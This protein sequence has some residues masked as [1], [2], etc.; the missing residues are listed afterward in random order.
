[1][2]ETTGIKNPNWRGGRVIAS[3]GY[4]LIRVGKNHHLADVR[5][6]A[7]EHRLVAEKKI[8]RSLLAGEHVHHIDGDTQN[9]LPSNLEVLTAAEHRLEHR[10]EDRGLR[11]PGEPNDLVFC[12]CG[13]CGEQFT[14]FDLSG[15]PRRFVSGHNPAPARS[16]EAFLAALADGPRAIREL[17]AQLDATP[18]AVRTMA[19]KLTRGGIV[20]RVEHG[21]YARAED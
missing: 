9:N 6:Y 3:N 4:V 17:A 10:T 21:V 13:G 1:M 16:R 2:G 18:G 7:Y 8:G 19:S 20:I 5:G 11:M 15:R 14:R 12:E